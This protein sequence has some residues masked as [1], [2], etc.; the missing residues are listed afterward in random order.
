[1][2]GPYVRRMIPEPGDPDHEV[3]VNETFHEQTDEELIDKELK[4]VEANDQAIQAILLGLPEDIYAGVDSYETAQEIWLHVQQIMKGSD[5]RIQEKKDKFF[6]EWEKFTSTDEESIESYYH[7]FSKLMNDFKRNKHFSEK[8]A[9]NLKFLNNL[10]SEWND[11]RAGRLVKTH[12]PLA[13]MANSNHPY[14]YPVF[15]LD[16]PSPS[17]YMQQPFSNN[18]NYNPQPSF[19]Q[20][21]MQQ[22]MSNLEDITDPTTAINMALVLISKAFKLNYSTPT[23]NNQRISSNQRNRQIAQP[24][25]N[26]GQDMH[27]VRG[28]GGNQFSQYARQNIRNQNGY[29]SVQNVKNQQAST[30]CTQTDKV[31]IYDSDG[32][33]E[34]SEQKDTAKG[35]SVNTQFCKQ[36]ILG[37]PPSSSKSKLYIV[38]PFAKSKGLPKID[39]SHSLS[40]PVTSNSIPVRLLGVD[41]TAKTKRPQLRSNTKNDSVYSASKSSCFKIKEVEVEEHHM[42]LLLFKNKKHMSSE[43]NNVK[44]AIWNDKYKVVYAMCHSNIFMVRRLRMFKAHDRQSEA[45]YKFRLEV[46]GNRPLWNDH[47]AAILDIGKLGAKGDI[48][49]FVG[50]SANSCTY[51]VYNQRTKKIMETMNVTFDELSAMAFEQRSSKPGLQNMTY[52]QISSGL[53]HTYA[54]ST[55][56]T[57]QPTERELDLQFEAM[58]DDYIGGQPSNAQRTV[59]AAQA[60]QVL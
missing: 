55:I 22:P 2:N 17:T 52:G 39:E 23:N 18:N 43:C 15:H 8:I 41:N 36:S 24:S 35:T 5:I 32:S 27:M 40:K 16:Q 30:S 51:R 1:M 54:P 48:G 28:N 42:N 9:S 47:V 3:L 6:N 12:D 11:L 37:K 59:P 46:L 50:Y 29:N 33:A 14:N 53:D 44:L 45:S 56:T 4:Q 21:Y 7:R 10:Q 19:N 58:Y 34:V 38:T 49:F 13:L 57:Q 60:P 25:M 20:N 31:P 26:M